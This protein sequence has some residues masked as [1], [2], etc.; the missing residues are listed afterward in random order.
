MR[1]SRCG[2]AVWLALAGCGADSILASGS[3]GSGGIEDD[4]GGAETS[5]GE[6][7]ETGGGEPPT[8]RGPDAPDGKPLPPVWR[9]TPERL[10]F[11]THA[12][13]Y[14]NIYSLP[15]TSTERQG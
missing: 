15:A 11:D 2:V 6:S 9:S 3:E 12:D 8:P 1:D 14:E 10:R 5:S 13:L 7:T 4:S